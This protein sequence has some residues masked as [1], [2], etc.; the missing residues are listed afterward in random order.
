M[1]A[2]TA[3]IAAAGCSGGD[4]S[5]GF[6][7][8]PLPFP[9]QGSSGELSERERRQLEV[10][11]STVRNPSVDI[12]SATRRQAA[13]ELIAMDRPEATERLADALTSGEPVVVLAVI[14]AME[15][16][17]EPVEGLLPAAVET[18]KD[19]SGQRLEKLSLVL[20][21]YGPEALAQVATTARDQSEMP[22][23]R[24]GPIYALSAFRSRDS[25]V[26]L[27]AILDEQSEE[28]M[29]IAAA[30]GASL[31]RLT[32]LPYGSDVKQW[33]Q[34]WDR[35]KDEPIEDWL[36]IMVLHLSTRTSELEGEIHQQNRE[37]DAIA[38]RLAEALRELFLSLSVD[39]Q[40]ERLPELLSDD[41]APVRE[42]ALGR[43][44]RRLRDSERI[45]EFVQE[46]VAERLN[47]PDELP[48]SR[49]L[50][51][52]LLS[53]LNYQRTAEMVAAVLE[54]QQDADVARGYLEILAKRPTGSAIGVALLWLDD[55]TT[56][57]AAANAV[58]A[59]ANN[60]LLDADSL[61][62]ARRVTRNACARHGTPAHVRLLGAIGEDEDL[63]AM[64]AHLDAA[65]PA[66]RRA[67]AEGLCLAGT[68]DPLLARIRDEEIYPYAIRLL[69]RGEAK[70]ATL[71]ALAELAPP[72]THRREWTETVKTVAD[73]LAPSDLAA[74]DTMLERLPHAGTQLR[75]DVLAR[76]A[77]MGL[78]DLPDEAHGILLGRLA[79][80]RMDLGD[81]QGAYDVL[82]R[83]NG[84]PVNPALSQLRFQA[85]VLSRH[86]DEAAQM[87]N[88]VT[89]W[90]RLFRELA[91]Q[92]PQAAFALRDEIRRRFA[93]RL[94]GDV[95]ESFRL[96]EQRLI[97]AANAESSD[98]PE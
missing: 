77:M 89:A 26:H 37:V 85:A 4:G 43:V 39:D 19:A 25:A 17:P 28:P 29:E 64:E 56:G 93:D 22:S 40:L 97:L 78:E 92:R 48:G 57:E 49:L 76:A 33:R 38:E 70:L 52:R 62:A 58:W 42:F 5:T 66:L 13:E 3:T 16:S 44:E 1:L 11:D 10:F 84:A 67:A 83:N 94:Q 23:R 90:V 30:S 69:A 82:A 20:P 41:L 34:W 96:A 45:P 61:P 14:D 65:E 2:A 7:G 55:S 60:G 71:R 51:A 24:I 95:A 73:R 35:L 91:D 21:R 18:L 87:D 36:R 98:S 88:D 75:A 54:E 6:L 86:F 27:M 63:A 31:E 79:R 15:A 59:M 12:N 50:A 46:K 81:Y 8:L 47:N 74:A 53:D 72:E 9:S 80:L 68:L 32:G